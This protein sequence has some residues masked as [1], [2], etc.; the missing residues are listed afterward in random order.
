M[1]WGRKLGLLLGGL[2]TVAGC[3]TIGTFSGGDV[4][5]PAL[6]PPVVP[7]TAA[8]APAVTPNLPVVPA[9][10]AEERPLPINLPAAL[11]LAHARAVDIATAAERIRVAAAVLEQA[12]TL[13]L[14]SISFGADYNRHDG[15]VQ[16]V[17][18]V[19]FNDSHSGLLL[20]AGSG[21]GPA[22]IIS[23]ND[24]IFAPL[25]AKQQVSAREADRQAVANDTLVAV[26]DAYFTVQQ[27]RGELAAAAET[28]RR[29]E[30]LVRRAKNLSPAIVPEFETDR[31]E[32]EL[33]RRQQAELLARERWQVAG[34]ELARVLRLEPAARLEPLEPPQLRVELIDVKKPVADLIPIALTN[35]P[36]L[37]SQQA[38]IQATL[39]QLKQERWRP[40]LPSI[41]LR[42]DATPVAGT[43]AG[44][45]YF[46][47]PNGSRAGARDDVDLQMLWQLN[48]LGFG[49]A[50]SIHQ[51]EA[52]NRTAI[53]D[54]SRIQDR[55]AAEV[56]QAYAQAQMA[57][58]RVEL[59]EKGVRSA[60]NSADKNLIGLGQTKG[61]GNQAVL[62]VRPQEAVAAVQALAQAYADYYGAVADA[63]RAQFRLYRALGQPAQCLVQDQHEGQNR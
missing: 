51:R 43:L 23:V 11:Q 6:A 58:R 1:D 22:A 3:Q 40:L 19:V 8:A 44:G 62:L 12:R 26:T 46:P 29:T 48:G 5:L 37:A 34:A 60:L 36:E 50:A 10:Q 52:E 41:L 13:W 53:L 7:A 14:P 47:S 30:E 9:S 56:A 20:G 55:V 38:Q 35:R 2:I 4:A 28:T 21:F 33:V 32:A 49:N 31:A 39:A 57:G 63:N 59:A 61:V 18:N 15:P 27:A 45:V 17:S 25:V 54:L 16:D 24:A 42:G